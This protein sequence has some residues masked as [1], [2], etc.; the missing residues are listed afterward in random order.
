VHRAPHGRPVPYALG[1]TRLTEGPVLLAPLVGDH[2]ALL[3][4][5]SLRLTWRAL[6]DG[7]ML[8]VFRP[9]GDPADP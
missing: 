9:T 2:E 7:R 6:P 1:R 4:G 5:Q 8:P 3:C